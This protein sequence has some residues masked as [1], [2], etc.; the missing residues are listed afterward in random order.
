[1]P[2]TS[3]P[4]RSLPASTRRWRPARSIRRVVLLGPTHRVA[5]N[6]LA[7]PASTRLRHAARRRRRSTR[8]RSPR[9]GICRRSSSATPHTP[10]NT[11]WKCS[12]PSCRRC[13]ASSAAAACRRP[14]LAGTGGRGARMPLGRRRDAARHQL[15]PVALPALRARAPDRRRHRPPHRRPRRRSSTISRPAVRRRST[16]CCWPRAGTACRRN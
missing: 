9:S 10:S 15:G 5:V 6:G 14:C 7:L 16:A 2:A 8:R 12:C 11:R 1:M 3:I 4:D 13:S